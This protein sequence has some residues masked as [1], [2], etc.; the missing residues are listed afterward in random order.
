MAQFNFEDFENQE[1]KATKDER[2]VGYFN[3]LKNDGDEAIVRFIYTDASEFDLLWV[4]NIKVGDFYRYISC[5]RTNAAEPIDKCPL[6][7][8]GEQL[9]ARFFI[10]LVEYVKDENGNIIAQAKVWDR[11]AKTFAKQIKS[12]LDEYGNLQNIVFKIKRRGVKGD[13]NTSYDILPANQSVYKEELYPKDFSAFDN[14]DLGHHSYYNLNY[15]EVNYFVNTGEI[16][17]REKEETTPT[18][19]T[20]QATNATQPQQQQNVTY[21]QAEQNPYPS[22]QQTNIGATGYYQQP[23]QQQTQQTTRRTYNY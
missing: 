13:M 14:F 16:P 23:T 19:Q 10:K 22:Q 1:K 12:F 21:Q 3:S 15:D 4:H 18:Q 8:K 7:E 9:K 11:P 17:P 2:K 5:L 20:A 6:C